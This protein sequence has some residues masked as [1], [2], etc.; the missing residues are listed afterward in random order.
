MLQYRVFMRSGWGWLLNIQKDCTL[1]LR[2]ESLYSFTSFGC[3]LGFGLGHGWSVLEAVLD[4]HLADLLVVV[5]WRQVVLT[6]EA[7]LAL[8]LAS[9]LLRVELDAQCPH[10]LAWHSIPR[11]GPS[12]RTR[13]SCTVHGRLGWCGSAAPRTTWCCVYQW[14]SALTRARTSGVLS[15]SN[16][17]P[18]CPRTWLAA[19]GTPCARSR[20]S[21]RWFPPSTLLLAWP[22]GRSVIVCWPQCPPG[23][24]QCHSLSAGRVGLQQSSSTP[25]SWPPS[26]S[27]SNPSAQR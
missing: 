18:V 4:A 14:K 12:G 13:C 7:S 6:V 25:S 3:R 23:R 8:L 2:N 10:L 5:G 27:T 19:S 1:L 24:C 22:R 9:Q 26:L 21:W 17:I 20:Q 11:W 15:I 16:S